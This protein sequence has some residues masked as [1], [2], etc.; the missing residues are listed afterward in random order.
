MVVVTGSS[1]FIGSAVIEKLARRFTLVG[2]DRESSPR[3]PGCRRMPLHRLHF[4][5]ERRTGVSACADS[6]WQPRRFGHSPR[7]L[8]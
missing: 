3:P 7:R 5:R 2:F 1:G 8:F 4:R 6:R